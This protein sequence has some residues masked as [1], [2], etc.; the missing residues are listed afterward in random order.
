M[1]I[2]ILFNDR[3]RFLLSFLILLY[4]STASYAEP[5][6]DVYL[7][8]QFL[9]SKQDKLVDFGFTLQNGRLTKTFTI[10]NPGNERLIISMVSMVFMSDQAPSCV[11]AFK[12]AGTIPSD[13]LPNETGKFTLEFVAPLLSSTPPDTYTCRFQIFNNTT[14]SPYNFPVTATVRGPYPLIRVFME[15]TQVADLTAGTTSSDPVVVALSTSMGTPVTKTFTIKNKGGG[16]L[17][18]GTPMLLGTHA[19]AFSISPTEFSPSVIVPNGEIQFDVVLNATQS[20]TTPL[21]AEVYF[22]NNDVSATPFNFRVQGIVSPSAEITVQHENSDIANNMGHIDF[23]VH[24]VGEVVTKTFVVKNV[25]SASLTLKNPIT[26]TSSSG[27]QL[28]NANFSKTSLAPNES[29]TFQVQLQTHQV[30]NFR[31]T[32]SFA[33]NDKDENPFSFDLTGE[34]QQ[35]EIEWLLENQSLDN[36]ATID[37]GTLR[38][39]ESTTKTLTLK[40]TGSGLLTLT[41]T[42]LPNGFYFDSP[43]LPSSLE[44]NQSHTM[45]LTLKG[46]TAGKLTRQFTVANNDTD[47][48][49]FTLNLVGEIQNP[50]IEVWQGTEELTDGK[51]RIDFG[52]TVLNQPVSKTL[53][54]KNTGNRPL[55][56][57]DMTLP[58][59]FS[60]AQTMPIEIAPA[61]QKTLNVQL[62]ALQT[63]NFSGRLFFANDDDNENPFNVDLTGH[64]N[65]PYPEI[66]VWL[67]NIEITSGS[68]TSLNAVHF[69]S[70]QQG[71]PITRTFTIKNIGNADL[72][73]LQPVTLVGH[74]FTASSFPVPSIVAPNQTSTFQVTLTAQKSGEFINLL[75]FVTDDRDEKTFSFPVKGVITASQQPALQLSIAG[76]PITDNP[77]W[78]FGNTTVGAS[79]MDSLIVRNIGVANLTVNV[80]SLTR[81]DFQVDA[82]NGTL[83]LLPQQET[84]VPLRLVANQVGT[85]QDT[86]IMQTNDAEHS[87]VSLKLT[88]QVIENN[89]IEQ[90][91]AQNALLIQGQCLSAANLLVESSLRSQLADVAMLGGIA[92]LGGQY[93]M[94]DT[95]TLNDDIITAGVIKVPQR[96]VGKAADIIVVGLHQIDEQTFN[97]YM[98]V[99][100]SSCTTGWR[101]APLAYQQTTALPGLSSSDLLAFKTVDPLPQYYSVP[102]YSGRFLAKGALDI[103]FGYRLQSGEVILAISPIGVVIK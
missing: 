88:G 2:N 74:E 92:R 97:W 24:T 21:E 68:D 48:N 96:D 34:V 41:Y 69:G 60:S 30:G 70:T 85:F 71:T 94:R 62:N 90:C 52:T 19:S 83:I 32:L 61:S 73:L 44:T 46:E 58:T 5:L 10:H 45:R 31:I 95:V 72:K 103:F 8:G 33:N 57:S 81:N 20:S 56:V 51:S 80:S 35:P 50:E 64:V 14:Q 17:T 53:T 87:I 54:L 99:D 78:N 38:P 42:S 16:N 77:T 55:I 91:F 1:N 11:D 49:P 18:L 102:M 65:M 101:I 36:G 66:E 9:P 98:L 37:F 25:G 23:G 26:L 84:Y 82:A 27:F 6:M 15:E 59:G 39:S 4:T 7:D 100:C 47:E 79:L 76:N 28:S 13:V 43:F 89:P 12:L 29:I 86:L 75:S 22:Q 93:Y 3:L 63:G 40:N 67:D